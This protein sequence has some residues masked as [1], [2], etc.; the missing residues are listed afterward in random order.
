MLRLSV[1]QSPRTSSKLVIPLRHEGR[2]DAS[3]AV[4]ATQL[5]R[6]YRQTLWDELDDT[7]GIDVETDERE[8]AA[9]HFLG[10]EL[11][12]DESSAENDDHDHYIVFETN[13]DLPTDAGGD[14]LRQAGERVT[15]QYR[16]RWVIENG[17]KSLKSFIVPT[18]S[19]SHTLRFSNFVF[20]VLL[21]DVWKRVDLLL[22]ELSGIEDRQPILSAAQVLSSVQHA[23]GV[24]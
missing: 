12:G 1:S 9:L 14:E 11:L 15:R 4:E 20:A 24:G 10:T 22:R 7:V 13:C 17:Y 6:E 21:Y 8:D 2:E 5:E 18:T 23:T 3:A 19:K 16:K